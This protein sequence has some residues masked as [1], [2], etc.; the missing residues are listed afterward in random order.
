MGNDTLTIR[1][2]LGNSAFLEDP[3]EELQ[4]VLAETAKD[5]L[6]SP[7]GPNGAVGDVLDSNGN[8]VGGWRLSDD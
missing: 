5:I 2:N 7:L 4:K 3:Y 1:I 8:T 6:H